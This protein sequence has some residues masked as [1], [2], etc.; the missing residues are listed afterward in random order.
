MYYVVKVGDYYVESI[1]VTMGQ[2]SE[3]ILSKEMMRN[4]R[5]NTAETLAKLTN[6]EVIKMA[7]QV[8]MCEEVKNE[9]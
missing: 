2:V 7:N 4:F 8:T 6:G 9:N 1:D 3:I 5:K